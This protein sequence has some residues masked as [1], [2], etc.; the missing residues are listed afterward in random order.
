MSNVTRAMFQAA[1]GAGGGVEVWFGATDYMQS[2]G[3]T[4]LDIQMSMTYG[5]NSVEA[6]DILVGCWNSEYKATV[7][8]GFYIQQPSAT[9]SNYN[10]YNTGAGYFFVAELENSNNV[11]IYNS[12]NGNWKCPVV[13]AVVKGMDWANLSATSRTNYYGWPPY[14]P[15]HSFTGDIELALVTHWDD[16]KSGDLLSL[17]GFEQGVKKTDDNGTNPED[18]TAE[19]WYGNPN[20]SQ[21]TYGYSGTSNRYNRFMS[22]ILSA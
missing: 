17:S 15:S 14:K 6:G 5:G 2:G 13:W 19:I 21:L 3:N 1:A 7:T 10:V 4:S 16:R 11:V 20:Q 8:S 22:V 12:S 9:L 18:Q